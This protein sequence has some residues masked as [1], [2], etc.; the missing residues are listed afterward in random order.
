LHEENIVCLIIMCSSVNKWGKQMNKLSR[1][2]FCMFLNQMNLYMYF[3]LPFI[4]QLILSVTTFL[5]YFDIID[6][7]RFEY[8]YNILI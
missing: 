4:I 2:T 1:W 3:I 8:K 6:N 7:F 5:I